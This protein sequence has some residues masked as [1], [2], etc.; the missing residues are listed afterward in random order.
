V[1]TLDLGSGK[2]PSRR[3][4]ESAQSETVGVLLLTGVI[5]ALVALASMFVLSGVDTAAPPTTSVEIDVDA[6]TVRFT[7]AGGDE[8]DAADVRVVFGRDGSGVVGLEN[9]TES[10]GD[11][12]GRFEAGERREATHGATGVLA[13]TVVHEPT[14]E[15]IARETADVPS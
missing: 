11:G 10:K 3:G 7:H 6:S 15:V 9:L 8:F 12:D 2:R 4:W 14:N 13:V 1:P 5:I